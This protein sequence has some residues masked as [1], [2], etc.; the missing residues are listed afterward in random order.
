MCKKHRIEK[1]RHHEANVQHCNIID[2]LLKELQRADKIT[3]GP[4]PSIHLIPESTTDENSSSID[5]LLHDLDESRKNLLARNKHRYN[6]SDST[7]SAYKVFYLIASILLTLIMQA[8]SGAPVATGGRSRERSYDPTVQEV[9]S[10]D[11]RPYD[12]SLVCPKCGRQYCVGQEQDLRR[13]IDEFC[14]MK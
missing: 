9:S 10:G 13:H 12:P 1:E 3:P 2:L 14:T 4:E 11:E 6:N 8:S 5:Q 7:T